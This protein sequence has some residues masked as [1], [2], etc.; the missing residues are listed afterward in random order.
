MPWLKHYT[1]T[2]IKLSAA[3][4]SLF[5]FFREHNLEKALNEAST[6]RRVRGFIRGNPSEWLAVAG[7]GE[8]KGPCGSWSWLEG[9]ECNLWPGNSSMTVLC[10][11][12]CHPGVIF[13]LI[14]H[15]CSGIINL[16][17][18]SAFGLRITEGICCLHS[19]HLLPT[20]SL[21]VYENT[22]TFY[23]DEFKGKNKKFFY[24]MSD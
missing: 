9:E 1:G 5:S 10:C 13:I 20:F 8:A 3:A 12:Q 22:L 16:D 19:L 11:L 7:Q 4:Q 17:A 24:S 6:R 23:K 2:I 15:L 18:A 21:F 14:H